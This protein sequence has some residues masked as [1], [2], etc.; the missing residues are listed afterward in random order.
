MDRVQIGLIVLAVL[1]LAVSFLIQTAT[2][3]Q[4]RAPEPDTQPAPLAEPGMRPSA[5][6]PPPALMTQEDMRHKE[7]HDQPVEAASDERELRL[8][9]DAIEM[10]VSSQGVR[11]KNLVLKRFDA[12]KVVDSERVDLVTW[13]DRG[14]LFA[15]LGDGPLRE[16]ET[17]NYRT[18]RHDARH[19]EFHAERGGVSVTRVIELDESG[20]GGRLRILLD[21]AGEEPVQSQIHLVFYARQ[22]TQAGPD[23]FAN[24]SMLVLSGDDVERRAVPGIGSPGFFSRLFGNSSPSSDSYA[25]PVEF[26]GTDSQY[27]LLAAAVEDA[28]NVNARSEPLARDGGRF[29]LSHPAVVL[30]PGTGLERSYRLYF[31]PKIVERVREVDARLDPA[32]N[33]GWSW[34]RPLVDLFATMLKWTY[35]HVA[36]NYGVAIILLTIV[37]RIAVYPLTQRSM[38]SMRRFSTLAPELKVIQEKH[39]GDRPKQQEEMM[40]LYREKGINP[41]TAMGGG[42]IPILIQMPFMISLYFALQSTIELRHAPFMLWID[43]LSAPEDLFSIGPIPI[44]VL[45]L[46]MGASMLLQQRLTP[47]PTADPQ[48]RQM[49]TVMSLMFIVLFYAFPSGLVLY[50]FVSN[51]LGIAQQALVNRAPPAATTN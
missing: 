1:L 27:F 40:K 3:P 45:P 42:C 35:G 38:K 20:Y 25:S 46:L 26:G 33:V 15:F 37:L 43:D 44:R 18:I 10:R 17:S 21:N 4:G 48:Q 47:N 23:R 9:N 50:W 11:V 8:E 2:P 13:P 24:Y 31:G 19:A 29:A 22:P 16:L 30:P 49:M 34:I 51:L 7:R 5:P 12:Q 32:L 6:T 28:Q 41:L 39:G 14:T 36:A